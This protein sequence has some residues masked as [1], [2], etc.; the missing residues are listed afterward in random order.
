MEINEILNCVLVFG[1]VVWFADF[2]FCQILTDI[3]K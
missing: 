3:I 1:K 2:Q